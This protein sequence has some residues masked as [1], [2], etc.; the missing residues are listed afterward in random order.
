MVNINRN[1]H[2]SGPVRMLGNKQKH[3]TSQLVGSACLHA[4]TNCITVDSSL[5]PLY[6]E[7]T[8]VDEKQGH[9]LLSGK[10]LAIKIS[11][12]TTSYRLA[13]LLVN[14]AWI[15]NRNT[16]SESISV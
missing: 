9:W 5:R 12:F 15:L 8:N 7:I 14:G 16:M 6:G 11:P 4:V 1:I 3:V 2:H 13:D 10:C